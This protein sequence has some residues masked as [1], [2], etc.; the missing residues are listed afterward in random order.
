[1]NKKVKLAFGI[2]TALCGIIAV[3]VLFSTAFGAG[4]YGYGSTRGNGYQI[5]F[6]Y[7]D[8]AAV[9]ALIAAFVL[10]LVAIGSALFG[11][12]MPGKISMFNL[13]VSA[14]LLIVGGILFLNAP[15]LY[16]AVNPVTNEYPVN[17]TGTILNAVFCFIGA[18]L[19]L[20]GAYRIRK[21]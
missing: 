17:G 16:V 9:G 8:K 19:G 13:G 1:M 4:A 6:G 2:L 3:L 14:I 12:F 20:Y 11:L 10:E 18:L 21:A 5:M 7:Q 15:N